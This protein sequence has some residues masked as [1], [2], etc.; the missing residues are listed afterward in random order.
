MVV[1]V[2]IAG[3]VLFGYFAGRWRALLGAVVLGAAMAAII[4]PWEASRLYVGFAWATIGV[5]AIGTGVT[6]RALFR[7]RTRRGARP[8]PG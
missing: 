5:I 4:D 6:V 1:T 3:S 8:S 7:V 2:L